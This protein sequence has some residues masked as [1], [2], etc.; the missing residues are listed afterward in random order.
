MKP[1]L[2]SLV[3]FVLTWCL[4]ETIQVSTGAI[5]RPDRGST[6]HWTAQPVSAVQQ[7]MTVQR[8]VQMPG[9]YL[10]GRRKHTNFTMTFRTKWRMAWGHQRLSTKLCPTPP[11]LNHS[12]KSRHKN[13]NPNSGFHERLK[14]R[15]LVP[16]T[17]IT[18]QSQAPCKE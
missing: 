7:C 9:F 5:P 8:C 13:T 2:T 16:K 17:L 18:G 14:L 11:N 15:S 4:T 6:N 10:Q 3:G 1:N 12:S